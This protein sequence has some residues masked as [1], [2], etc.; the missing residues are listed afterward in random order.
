VTPESVVSSSIIINTSDSPPKTNNSP[1]KA[2]KSSPK[3]KTN[4]SSPKGR[5][6]P[7]SSTSIIPTVP[8]K[9]W[10]TIYWLVDELRLDRTAPVDTDDSEALPDGSEDPKTY[11]FQILVALL[12]SSQTKD[13]V[14]GGTM[15]ALQQH[16]LTVDNII[17]TSPEQVNALIGKVGFHNNKTKYLKQVVE[18]LRDQYDGDLP[19]ALPPTP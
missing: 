4:N 15:R 12:L 7:S 19:P 14:V 13:A 10:Q 5:R 17:A 9:D 11:R 18:I 16:G 6:T 3:A 2:K 8:P 1:P